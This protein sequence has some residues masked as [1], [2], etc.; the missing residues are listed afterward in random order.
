MFTKITF[1]CHDKKILWGSVL[2]SVFG[3]KHFLEHF[4]QDHK[5]R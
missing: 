5:D 4:L 2:A 1:G 3:T